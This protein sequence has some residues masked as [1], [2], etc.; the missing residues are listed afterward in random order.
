MFLT[1]IQCLNATIHISL[2]LLLGVA[3]LSLQLL[4]ILHFSRRIDPARE[5]KYEMRWMDVKELWRFARLLCGLFS[6]RIYSS[7]PSF[8]DGHKRDRMLLTI[9]PLIQGMWVKS[10][11]T[12]TISY[13][14]EVLRLVVQYLDPRA[15]TLFQQKL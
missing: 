3:V 15:K 7:K 12:F 8:P 14:A 10:G 6:E 5:R 1:L 9:V 13:W 2:A 4:L 11:I